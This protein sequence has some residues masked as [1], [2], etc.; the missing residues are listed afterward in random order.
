MWLVEAHHPMSGCRI[1][2]QPVRCKVYYISCGHIT[3]CYRKTDPIYWW[4]SC[5]PGDPTSMYAPN[6]FWPG[7]VTS[8]SPAE[9]IQPPSISSILKHVVGH[10]TVLYHWL[11]WEWYLAT[12]C[13]STLILK[14]KMSNILPFHSQYLSITANSLC[15]WWLKYFTRWKIKVFIDLRAWPHIKDCKL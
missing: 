14:K 10:T 7:A 12:N 9:R 4:G 1:T 5:W 13:L 11:R 6:R 8:S 15:I 3:S 2:H